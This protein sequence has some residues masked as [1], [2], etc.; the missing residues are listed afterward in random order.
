MM[1]KHDGFKVVI[2][3]GGP[4]GL[5]AA[6]WCAD[7]GLEAI[8]ID[9]G[10]ELGG[11]LLN[12]FNPIVNYPGVMTGN[13]RELRDRI[14][15]QAEGTVTSMALRTESV[16]INLQNRTVS[17]E[18]GTSIAGRNIIIAT[19]VRRRTLGIPGEKELTGRGILVSGARDS[20]LA[21]GKTVAVIGGGDAA[22]E[23]ALILS[24]HSTLVY[25]VHRRAEFS[26]RADFVRAV[27]STPNIRTMMHSRVTAINGNEQ[28]ETV[29]IS[30]TDPAG[31][32][33]L[34]VEKVLIRIGVQPN[35]ELVQGSLTLD[36]SG[37]I[38]VD[39]YCRTSVR[40]VYAVGDVASPAAPTISGAVG[41]GA[42]AAKAIAAEINANFGYDTRF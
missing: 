41:G 39:Q 9:R 4:A 2:V 16:G 15:S 26:A 10:T 25:V 11:Q 22:L 1:T 5:S 12:I 13:G 29:D 24:K 23:N 38:L 3:G 20:Y 34:P 36:P 35:S 37:Y 7:L 31:H 17:I 28:V 19:G 33:S 30:R 27:R 21:A 18:G 32:L 6:I 40:G 8:L 42:T 14:V